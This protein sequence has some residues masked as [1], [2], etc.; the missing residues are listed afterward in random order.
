LGTVHPADLQS[1][2]LAELETWFGSAVRQWRH[3]R[4]YRIEKALPRQAP[5]SGFAGPGF[6]KKAGLYVCGDHLW[7][8]SIEG[9]IL[10]GLRTADAILGS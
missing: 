3:L 7:S 4:T 8:A 2:V 1:S 5:G 9:S 10:S 6:R